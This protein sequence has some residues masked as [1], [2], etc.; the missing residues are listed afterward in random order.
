VAPRLETWKQKGRQ[1][2]HHLLAM[3]GFSLEHCKQRYAS[4]VSR[5]WFFLFHF[6]YIQIHVVDSLA[7]FYIARH[8]SS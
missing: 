4:M 7:A 5:N 1:Q 6:N 2:L 3:M 8:P